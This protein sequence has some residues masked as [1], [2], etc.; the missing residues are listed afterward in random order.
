MTEKT[1]RAEIKGDIARQY[2]ELR[3]FRKHGVVAAFSGRRYGINFLPQKR[4][5]ITIASRKLFC[6]LAGVSF[7]HLICLEQVHGANI[8]RATEADAGRGSRDLEN[9]LGATDAVIT[10]VPKLVLSIRT[11]DC[12]PVFIMDPVKRAVGVA[13]IGWRGAHAGLAGKMV[14]AFRMQ[15]LSKPED[16]QVAFGP[17]IRPCCYEVGGE[18][19]KPFGDFVGTR[20]KKLYFDLPSWIRQ[21]L[22][23]NGVLP[24]A[25]FDS[26]ICTACQNKQFPSYRK[27]GAEVRPMWSIISLI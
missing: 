11:A 20:N 19:R 17:M 4:N 12:G 25:I 5:S 16:L 2:Y 7:K 6:R 18:F 8:A 13:H 15:F 9:Q 1:K 10:D 24:E 3:T 14:Q 27:E 21:D 23:E 26:N 22:V